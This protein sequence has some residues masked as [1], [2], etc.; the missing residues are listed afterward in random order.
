[1]KKIFFILI[2]FI[3]T[4]VANLTYADSKIS[5]IVVA[6][7]SKTV[8]VNVVA[9]DSP[10]SVCVGYKDSFLKPGGICL[11]HEEKTVPVVD[12]AVVVSFVLDISKVTTPGEYDVSLKSGK[13][14]KGIGHFTLGQKASTEAW[15]YFGYFSKSKDFTTKTLCEDDL[16]QVKSISVD[17]EK[18]YLNSALC[19]QKGSAEYNSKLATWTSAVVINQ[20]QTQKIFKEDY[21]LLAPIGDTTKI[22][23][24]TKVGDYLNT[25][26][27]IAIGLCGALAVIMIVIYGVQYMGDESVFGKTEA[28][29]H[30]MAAI[31]GLLLALGAYTILNTINP[32]LV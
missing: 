2:L 5:S 32:N 24:T 13:N 15:M 22:D 7:D 23:G 6:G 31:M 8:T 11:A 19:L 30:I 25:I 10:L 21:T 17:P 4:G 29:S 14:S 20:N 12:P 26:L 9:E 16:K 1:M 28:K 18:T 3:F 27:L